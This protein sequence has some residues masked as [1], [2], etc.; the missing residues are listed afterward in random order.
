MDSPTGI[1]DNSVAIIGND[2]RS[3]LNSGSR[4]ISCPHLLWN[5]ATPY[6]RPRAARITT[7]K[8]SRGWRMVGT[9]LPDADESHFPPT[10]GDRR[11]SPPPPLLCSLISHRRRSRCHR[12]LTIILF[13]SF[14][15]QPDSHHPHSSH[16]AP[17]SRLSHRH[18][19]L[20]LSPSCLLV[21][22]STLRNSLSFCGAERKGWPW[23][24]G[25]PSIDLMEWEKAFPRN[26]MLDSL[27]VMT[28]VT[29]HRS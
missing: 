21:P 12:C 8:V 19:S 17:P 6:H 2:F 27:F 28:S 18:L 7:G 3:F 15:A 14:P 16:S 22:I 29:F 9:M 26:R 5:G 4:F 1:F 24:I 25:R 10:L 13:L 11:P 23:F 20:Y